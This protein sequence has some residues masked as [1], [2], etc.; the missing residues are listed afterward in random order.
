M[1]YEINVAKKNK[2]G[3]YVHLFATAERSLTYYKQV[4]NLL[5]KFMIMFPAPEHN[6]SVHEYPEE[7]TTYEPKE[8]LKKYEEKKHECKICDKY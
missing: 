2:D 1:Y 8:F 3:I 7:F 5:K 6:I 4:I